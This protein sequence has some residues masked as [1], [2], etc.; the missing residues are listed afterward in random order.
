MRKSDAT[1]EQHAIDFSQKYNP[2]EKIPVPIE[3]IIE[4]QLKISIIPIKGLLRLHQIDAFLS[5]DCQKIYI[6]QDNYIS[7]T[8]RARF[9]LAHEVGH[10]V[11][12]QH[13]IKKIKNIEDW[14]THILGAGTGRA[15]Y[16][17][18]ANIFAGCL[19]FP[20]N[21]LLEACHDAKKKVAEA[22][23]T[24]KA[25]IPQ[26]HTIIPYL[27]PHIAKRFEVSV[28]PAEIRLENVFNNVDE[29]QEFPM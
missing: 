13:I 29:I 14:K 10:A 12:H 2:N 15:I 18:E 6:D 16:E 3:E 26:S 4:L 20:S 25:S 23:K 5:H 27:A 1:I 24:I 21:K 22:F 28:Q 8:T 9:T 17:T 19:L 11:M 7:Q